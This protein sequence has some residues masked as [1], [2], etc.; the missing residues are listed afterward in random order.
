VAQDVGVLLFMW[1]G[2][3]FG[4]KI[5]VYR[6]PASPCCDQYLVNHPAMAKTHYSPLSKIAT[7]RV[8]P[9]E[10][11]RTFTGKQT[12]LKPSAGS[13]SRLCSFSRWQ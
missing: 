3:N 8:Q 5:L 11:D 7:A 10:A 6:F 9:A 1:E 2:A 13:D 4:S 12:T